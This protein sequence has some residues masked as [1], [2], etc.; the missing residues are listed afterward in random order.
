[1]R[2]SSAS[3]AKASSRSKRAK[4]ELTESPTS[5]E[6]EGE[7][8]DA[9]D[10]RAFEDEDNEM[11]EVSSGGDEGHI[12]SMLATA[13][14]SRGDAMDPDVDF[15]AVLHEVPIE[16]RRRLAPN[17]SGFTESVTH[18]EEFNFLQR[19]ST[20]AECGSSF[21]CQQQDVSPVLD[22][23]T[24]EEEEV[25]HEELGAVRQRKDY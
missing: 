2:V 13:G 12:E 18:S 20:N 8:A 10:A 23:T 21:R 25:R 24:A 14:S 1:M 5:P 9:E 16:I 11:D 6:R 22:S 19:L 17:E 7:S 3:A 4:G 15:S